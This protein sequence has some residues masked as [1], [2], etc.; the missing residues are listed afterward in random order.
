ME[1]LPIKGPH[2][3]PSQERS[4]ASARGVQCGGLEGAGGLPGGWRV[5][6][7]G[8]DGSCASRGPAVTGQLPPGAV[9]QP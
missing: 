5:P 2:P 7:E 4:S 8:L 6:A 3:R 1:Q 9:T